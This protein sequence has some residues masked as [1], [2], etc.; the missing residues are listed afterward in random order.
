MN[1]CDFSQAPIIE[2]LRLRPE[3]DHDIPLPRYMSAEAAG[4]DICAAIETST[5]LEKGQIMLVSTG[6]AMALPSGFEAQ[7]RPRSGLA[8]NH[9]IGLI[10]SPGTIDADYRGEVKVALI[11]LGPD[12][13]T[14]HRGDRIAQMV[15]HCCCRA[16]IHTVARLNDTARNRGG[17]GHT[18]R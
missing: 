12:A 2:F 16:E 7:I 15:I 9:G 1:P 6:F 8:V 17:F 18:G 4:M 14:I 3:Q 10:N 11:N 13:Y 5:L